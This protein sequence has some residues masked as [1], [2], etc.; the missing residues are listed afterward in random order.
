MG[1][2]VGLTGVTGA[3]LLANADGMARAFGAG[4][5]SLKGFTGDSGASASDTGGAATLGGGGAARVRFGIGP[6]KKNNTA[7]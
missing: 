5:T 7:L 4:S 2:L 1:D 3:G 6:A